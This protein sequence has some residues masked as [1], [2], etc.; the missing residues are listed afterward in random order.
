MKLST[1]CRYGA[2]ALL[3]IARNYKNGPVSRVDIERKQGISKAYLENILLSLR[4][5]RIIHTIRGAQG[6]FELSKN[7][8]DIT[9][10]DVVEAVDGPLVLVDCLDRDDACER[11]DECPLRDV[12]DELQ[13][14]H[15]D[16]L[17]K[18]TLADLLKKE[19]K[20]NKK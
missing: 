4:D 17:G 7:P 8:A 1:K 11:M 13:T 5:N 14:A 6:G 2:R 16:V 12:W 10:L 9:L 19:K 18:I 15:H 20:K 3:E